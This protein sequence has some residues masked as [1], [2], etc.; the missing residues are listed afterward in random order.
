MPTLSQGATIV[1][2]VRPLPPTAIRDLTP[3]GQAW[4]D[5]F[6]RSLILLG[7]MRRYKT[8]TFLVDD[9]TG[10]LVLCQ[11]DD[12]YTVQVAV[13]DTNDVTLDLLALDGSVL[14]TFRIKMALLYNRSPVTASRLLN[15]RLTGYLP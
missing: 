11:Y 2:A 13:G 3:F 7:Q 6:K 5:F 1:P 8:Y 10:P 15:Q 12:Q 9:P 4:C 14:S